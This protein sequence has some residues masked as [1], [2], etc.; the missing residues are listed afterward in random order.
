VH[1]LEVVRLKEALRS[2]PRA[3]GLPRSDAWPS[4]TSFAP[5]LFHVSFRPSCDSLRNFRLRLARPKS[6]L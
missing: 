6:C 3:D 5:T 4:T 2:T 1:A